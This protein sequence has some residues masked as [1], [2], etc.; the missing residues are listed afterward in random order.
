MAR[1]WKPR[2]YFTP[3]ILGK[4]QVRQIAS[5]LGLD[6]WGVIGRLVEFWLDAQV[7][8]TDAGELEGK[9]LHWLDLKVGKPG[10]AAAMV[11]VG[12]LEVTIKGIKVPAFDDFISKKAVRRMEKAM[13]ASANREAAAATEGTLGTGCGPN[14]DRTPAQPKPRK[15]RTPKKPQQPVLPIE[16]V[17]KE[18]FYRWWSQYPKHRAWRHNNCLK[19]W[20][21][22]SPDDALLARMLAA[23]ESQKRSEQWIKEDGEYV[24]AADNWLIDR[25]WEGSD[26]PRS[27]PAGGRV[28][29]EPGQFANRREYKP[30]KAPAPGEPPAEG[31]GRLF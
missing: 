26:L 23:L 10:F 24:P 16:D 31:G 21:E 4:A 3:D 11:E 5:S 29:S 12:W 6:H 17:E 9:S 7:K 20:R 19:L 8:A 28:Q 18:R 22:L 27:V 15:P 13:W 25:R 14:V 1:P 2:I 30:R